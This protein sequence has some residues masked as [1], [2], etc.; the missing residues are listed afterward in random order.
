MNGFI[1]LI[2]FLLV[3]FTILAH[4]NKDA[5][6]R[7]AKFHTMKGVEVI[8]YWIYQFSNVAIFVYL[9]FLEVKFEATW[10]FAC[11]VG[12]YLMGILACIFAIINFAKPSATGMNCN[13]IYRYSR[14]PMYVAYFIFFIGC[15]LLTQSIILGC[16]V[17]IFQ[18]SAH[19]IILSEERWCIH[20][21]GDAYK[22]YMK[23][24]RRYI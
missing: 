6:A 19:W 3:R 1:L 16:V 4:L 11:G 22:Q 24:V 21:F 10:L 9:I 8:A 15:A 2:P 7:A 14:N 20:Q 23:H 5:I 17:G 18:L 12:V 13:G